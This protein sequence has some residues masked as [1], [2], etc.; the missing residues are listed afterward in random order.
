MMLMSFCKLLN[1]L[2]HFYLSVIC[3]NVT[4]ISAGDRIVITDKLLRTMSI[5]SNTE[6]H[7]KYSLQD[8]FISL[9]I[10]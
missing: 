1:Y 5:L 6:N 7:K 4:C 8:T 9:L 2:H 3:W 10:S